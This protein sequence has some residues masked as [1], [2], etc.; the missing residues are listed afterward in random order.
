VGRRAVARPSGA[1]RRCPSAVA[2]RYRQVAVAVVFR[3]EEA[4]R[5]EA[6]VQQPW[7][8]QESPRRKEETTIEVVSSFLPTS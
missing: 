4:R 3:Q 8:R 2:V 1:L 5:A 7:I 6:S